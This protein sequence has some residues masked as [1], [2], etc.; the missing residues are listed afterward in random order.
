MC[1]KR[2]S[3]VNLLKKR[4]RQDVALS[5]PFNFYLKHFLI[6]RIINEIFKKMCKRRN[7]GDRRKIF[8]RKLDFVLGEHDTRGGRPP[9]NF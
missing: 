9:K 2:S 8:V 1:L 3:L 4:E 6:F 5:K 7:S